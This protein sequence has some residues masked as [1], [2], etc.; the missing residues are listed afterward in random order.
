MKLKILFFSFDTESLNKN[1]WNSQ[2][3]EQEMM[4]QFQQT[5]QKKINVGAQQLYIIGNLFDS[6]YFLFCFNN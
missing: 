1:L 3:D 6:I 2:I 5:A 4:S